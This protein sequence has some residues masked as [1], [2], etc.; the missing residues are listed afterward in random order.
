[1][2]NDNVINIISLSEMCAH[3]PKETPLGREVHLMLELFTEKNIRIRYNPNTV[4]FDFP[5]FQKLFP[6]PCLVKELDFVFYG[7]F[8]SI[9]PS[10][11]AIKALTK[12]EKESNYK[13]V[14]DSCISSIPDESGKSQMYFDKLA[15]KRLFYKVDE[16][17]NEFNCQNFN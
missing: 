13:K 3:F 15:Q 5:T 16:T 4:K 8:A 2:N 10:P 9:M 6:D 12:A 7:Q 1:M 14:F 17:K 11:S